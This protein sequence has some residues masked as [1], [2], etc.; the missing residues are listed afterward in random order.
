MNENTVS[1]L[2]SFFRIFDA[3]IISLDSV[4]RVVTGKIKYL[5]ER[6][7][8]QFKWHI[9]DSSF[10]KESICLLDYLLQTKCYEGNRISLTKEELNQQYQS[11]S[12]ENERNTLAIIFL[13]SV[14]INVTESGKEPRFFSIQLK[15]SYQKVAPAEYQ[16]A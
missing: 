5:D 2:C 15:P 13:L 12:D 6:G 10:L 1:F 11:Y 16:A 7:I 4:G 3:Y 14:R 9:P 8:Q